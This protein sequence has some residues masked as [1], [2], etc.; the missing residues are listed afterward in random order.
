MWV[1][2]AN[3]TATQILFMSS[4]TYSFKLDMAGAVAGDYLRLS[5]SSNGSSFDIAN[6]TAGTHSWSATT[7]KHIALSWDGTTYRVWVDGE[8]DISVASTTS[9]YQPTALRLGAAS[10]GMSAGGYIDAVRLV[11]YAKFKGAGAITPPVAAPTY[12]ESSYY[13][14]NTNI[15]KMY[16]GTPS[17]WVPVKRLFVGECITNASDIIAGSVRT[18]AIQGKYYD[19][20]SST[21]TSGTYAVI[22]KNHNIG[23]RK[24]KSKAYLKCVIAEL[25]YTPGDVTDQ[26]NEVATNG[27]GA[28]WYGPR[29]GTLTRNTLKH[30][31]AASRTTAINQTNGNS[32]PVTAGYWKYVFQLERDFYR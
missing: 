12:D 5:L 24:I 14:Y 11:P 32:T 22:N 31:T 25:G 7:F 30:I 20:T 2:T 21:T 4:E 15:N 26:F 9:V 1:Y 8:L 19:D 23:T 29:V 16:M 17:S 10:G 13:W 18:Y 3:V 28:D 6:A 27:L